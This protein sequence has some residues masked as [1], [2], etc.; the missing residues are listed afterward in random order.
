MTTID[1]TTAINKYKIKVES[2]RE[3]ESYA[4]GI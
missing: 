3:H 1:P 4:C 2:E